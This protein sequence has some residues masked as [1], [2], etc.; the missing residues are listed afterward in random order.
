MKKRFMEI[1]TIHNNN[2]DNIVQYV[3]FDNTAWISLSTMNTSPNTIDLKS[4]TG[5]NGAYYFQYKI[6]HASTGGPSNFELD[7]IKI[8][9]RELGVR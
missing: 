7:E 8:V 2:D 1:T 3:K 6:V 4:L 9:Y 5:S